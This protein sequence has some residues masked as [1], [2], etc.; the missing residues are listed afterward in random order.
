M[1]LAKTGDRTF[2]T[3]GDEVCE[4]IERHCVHTESVWVGQ[5]F[6]LMP[7]QRRMLYELFEIDPETGRYRYRMALVG[8]PRKNGKSELAAS[9]A[10]WIAFGRG[11]PSAAVY[12]AAAS[13]SQADIVFEK[14]R[15]MVELSP[16]LQH[17]V[18][19][20]QGT[21]VSEPKL[22]S[23]DNPYQF[24]QRLSSKG[25]TKHGLNPS[26]VILDELHAWG[27]GQ[28]DELYQALTTAMAARPNGLIFAITTAGSDI[29]TSRCG[30]LYKLGRKVE[31][32]ESTAPAFYFR[33]WEAPEGCALDDPEAWRVANPS[34]GYTVDEDYYQNQ[35]G[36]VPE[37]DFR[38][39]YL[40]QWVEYAELPWVTQQEIQSCR[41]DEFEMDTARD[42]W[43]GVDLSTAR[44]STAV[45]WGQWWDGEN[46]PCGHTGE[47][48][49]YLMVRTWERPILPD[50]SY[51]EEWE[52]PLDEVRDF[53]RE[54]NRD[55]EVRA[56]IFDPYGSNLMR[57]D[58]E[59]EGI[60]C[61]LMYQQGQR[62]MASA[63]GMH[64]LIVQRRLHYWQDVFER[65]VM[66]T[67]T[68][69]VGDGYYLQKR[70]K[71]KVMDAAQAASQVVYG[72]LYAPVPEEVGISIYVPG[73]DD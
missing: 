64:E 19:V 29:E 71:G 33:W 46:R 53:L 56:N 16:T 54:L 70:R 50:G 38:R 47:P 66:A 5:P 60:P 44:D 49:L 26:A 55:Y 2:L 37:A 48:C 7:W 25:S 59:A 13:E 36:H 10:L 65:H 51:D 1:R 57:L 20:P 62:R 4:W 11:E 32:G 43:V 30:A 9:L 35:I 68:R 18:S 28:G 15:R 41:V 58:L 40:N 42:T 24:V 67:T 61:E 63:A 3:I 6:Q 27:V 12:C 21:R 34:L 31:R 72:T 22:T 39:L 23:V 73:E 69:A 14:A 52:V 17:M 45:A 8:V